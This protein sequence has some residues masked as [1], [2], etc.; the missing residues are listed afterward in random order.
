MTEIEMEHEDDE[1]LLLYMDEKKDDPEN[2][3]RA[4]GEFFIRYENFVGDLCSYILSNLVNGKSHEDLVME[5]FYRIYEKAGTFDWG[6]ANNTSEVR[7]SIE[8][9]IT[10]I[11]KNMAIDWRRNE[12][13]ESSKLEEYSPIFQE[14]KNGTPTSWHPLDKQAHEVLSEEFDKLSDRDKEIVK[15]SGLYFNLQKG[16]SDMPSEV[17]EQI[18]EEYDTTPENIRQVRF[19]FMKRVKE[20]A[21]K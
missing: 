20:K 21:N 16:K 7:K 18:V 1:Y 12:D 5:V 8:L 10:R 2:A 11:A 17:I 3:K 6:K 9:W 13:R 14:Q 4:F 15:Q 19:R